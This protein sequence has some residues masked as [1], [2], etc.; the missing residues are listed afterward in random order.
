MRKSLFLLLL[1]FVIVSVADAQN[2]RR[3]RSHSSFGRKKP[4]Y[5]YEMIGA[6]GVANFLGDLGGANQIGTNGLK[7]LELALTRPALG[8][9]AR[10]KIEQFFSAKGNFYWG[11]IRGDDKLTKEPFRSARNLNF[12]SNIFEL[13]GQIEFNFIKD[14]KGHVYQI[15]GVRGIRHKDKSMYLFVG[16]GAVHFNPK[17]LYMGKWVPLQPLHTEGEG[18]LPGVKKY[19][20]NTGLISVGGG[21]RLALNKYW[22]IGFELGMRKTFTDYMD[23]VSK[24][25]PDPAIFNGDPKAT[26]LSNPSDPNSPNYCEPCIGEQRGDHTDKD[27]YMFGTLTLGYKVMHKKRSRSKF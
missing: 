15:R 19:S 14:Q 21:F 2:H 10:M 3:N 13:S 7:D 23:D 1:L 17:G 18:I 20:R 22:G 12:K 9:G 16:G 8:I 25:Y 4:P 5:R 27:A 26:Y 11:I 6:L 24:Y